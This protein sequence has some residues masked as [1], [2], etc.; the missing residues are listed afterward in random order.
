MPAG[1]ALAEN[2][3]GLS[4]IQFIHKTGIGAR[5]AFVNN[6]GDNIR[7]AG[8]KIAVDNE[9]ALG[10]GLTLTHYFNRFFSLEGAAE[11][12]MG[13]I[14]YSSPGM[15]VDVGDF[16]QFPFLLTA[17]VHFP[18]TTRFHPY[19][20]FGTGFYY[21][22]IDPTNNEE[23]EKI[24]GAGSDL[25]LDYS[26]GWHT[27]AGAEVF[28]NNNFAMDV[29]FRYTWNSADTELTYA[30]GTVYEDAMK[31]DSMSTWVGMKAYF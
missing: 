10:A 6:D 28:F 4:D 11:F 26:I 23:I 15:T 18:T 30:D 16:K 9:T 8:T 2:T 22:M 7:L 12:V 17:R 24:F 20:G 29:D 5:G 19:V 1:Y 3:V 21:N 27:C 25:D 31:L 13:D 14:E